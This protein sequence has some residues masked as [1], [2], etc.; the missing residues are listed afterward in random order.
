MTLRSATWWPAL[1]GVLSL[2]GCYYPVRDKIDA[3][4]CDIAKQP[5]DVQ[6]MEAPDQQPLMPPVEDDQLTQAAYHPDEDELAQAPPADKGKGVNPLQEKLKYPQPLSVPPE[7]L[8]N[9]S[10]AEL[11]LAPLGTAKRREQLRREFPMLRPPGPDYEGVPGPFGHPL[12]LAELQRIGMSSS[13]AIKQAVAAVEVARGNA[14]QAGLMPNP[15]LGFEVDTFGT[16][17]GAGYAGGY[18]DQLIKTA[19]KLRLARVVAAMDLR[20]AEV[21]LRRAQMDLATKIRTYYFQLLV[22][23]ENM[24]INRILVGFTNT[25]Y[26]FQAGQVRGR[27]EFNVAPYEAMYLRALANTAH[28]NLIFAR[29]NYV[30]TWKQ[31]TSVLG[32][33]GMPLTQVAGQANM[34]LPL[35]DFAKVWNHVGRNHTDV[36]TAENDLQQARF[37]LLLAQVQPY[38][39]VDVRFLIQK[40]YT[41]PPNEIAPSIAVSVPVPIWNRNQGGIAAAQ[42]NVVQRGEEPLRVRND[43]YY[44]LSDAFGRYQ[45]FHQNLILFRDKILPD[46]VRVYDA[47]YRRYQLEVQTAPPPGVLPPAVTITLP[48]INDVVVAQQLLVTNIASYITNLGGMWQAVVDVTDLIQTNDMFR[49]GGQPLPTEPMPALPDLEQLKPLLPTHP[50]SPLPDPHLRG[51]DGTWPEAIPTRNNYPMPPA[52]G[53]GSIPQSGQPRTSA[54]PPASPAM[55]QAPTPQQPALLPDLRPIA[56]APPTRQPLSARAPEAPPRVDPQLLEPPPQLPPRPSQ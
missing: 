7:L 11:R 54:A 36:V 24:R 25:V 53:E 32:L 3:A 26:E 55:P 30:A 10:P 51:G 12:T 23:R 46:L 14:Y 35:F 5:F 38:P 29:N 13:P 18:M 20:N 40:D 41:G 45:T 48:G 56:Q 33:P 16:T 21:A 9:G 39:D 34:P 17:G 42:A 52:D 8:P 49:M 44:R 22:A 2:C 27:A 6:H 4:V 43:L 31:L 1:L 37:S 47:I 19:G 15:I 28:T 50:C